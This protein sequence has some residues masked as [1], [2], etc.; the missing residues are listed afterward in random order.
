MHKWVMEFIIYL[1]LFF[2]KFIIY[3]NKTYLIY[4]FFKLFK[5]FNTFIKLIFNSIKIF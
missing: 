1:L 3:F 4:F 5:N 2:Y